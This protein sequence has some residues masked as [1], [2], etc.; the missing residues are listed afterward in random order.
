MICVSLNQINNDT[1]YAG[2]KL[3]IPSYGSVPE[4]MPVLDPL[5]LA[6]PT[7]LMAPEP[8]PIAEA[9]PVEVPEGAIGSGQR[10]AGISR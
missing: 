6:E 1:I 10:S 3:Y 7:P 8:A 2:R 4:A 9:I 5:P